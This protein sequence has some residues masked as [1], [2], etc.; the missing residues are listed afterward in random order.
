MKLIPILNTLAVELTSKYDLINF[1]GCCWVAGVVGTYLEAIRGVTDITATVVNPEFSYAVDEVRGYIATNTVA[2]WNSNGLYFNH[3]LVR[4][5]WR[6]RYY[7]FD[8]D[9]GC[10]ST[11]DQSC[12]FYDNEEC[13]DLFISEAM[14]LG[15]DTTHGSWNTRFDRYQLSGMADMIKFKLGHMVRVGSPVA[16]WAPPTDNSPSDWNMG[17]GV[18][19]RGGNHME[20]ISQFQG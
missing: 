2:D 15:M 3:I 10:I 19:M 16:K 17:T 9:S 4:F 14:E 7:W 6:G 18:G 13:G 5:C 8:T 12:D 11:M 1:G 20:L